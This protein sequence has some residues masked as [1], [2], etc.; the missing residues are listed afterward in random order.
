MKNTGFTKEQ[1]AKALEQMGTIDFKNL[2]KYEIVDSETI[3]IKIKLFEGGKM[4]VKSTKGAA[5]YDCYA[6]TCDIVTGGQVKF[7]L[8]F[9]LEL[10]NG[11]CAKIIARSSVVN[12]N[13]RLANNIGLIDSDYRGE[14]SA[15]FDMK[16]DI[17]AYSEDDRV[18]QLLI[19]K[20]LPTTLIEVDQLSE[21]K[22]GSGG[23]G[24]TGK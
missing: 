3:P 22:R 24:S 23:Y 20:V 15:V 4:P 14:V 17:P 8:G 12:T 2:L 21:T 18:C 11:Y 1:M 13:L 9:A 6:R 7:G 16:G 10:P 19:E 5:A